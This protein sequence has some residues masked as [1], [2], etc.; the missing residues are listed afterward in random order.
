MVL[1]DDTCEPLDP[2]A[3]EIGAGHV[4]YARVKGGDAGLR[5]RSLRPRRERRRSAAKRC[6]ISRTGASSGWRTMTMPSA[7]R[8]ARQS[9]RGAPVGSSSIATTCS[10][11][12]ASSRS[13]PFVVRDAACAAGPLEDA[14]RVVFPG[15]R[16]RGP[17]WVTACARRVN[18]SAS[19][20]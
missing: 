15:H 3:L 7:I 12:S 11:Y 14:G 8:V 19:V 5:R 2:T 13:S 20:A 18:R 17:A 4:L 9:R 1:N 16:V 10:P 6:A